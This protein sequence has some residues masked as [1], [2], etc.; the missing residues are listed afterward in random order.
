MDKLTFNMHKLL[1]FI[2]TLSI[3]TSCRKS[4]RDND[5]ET[6]SAVA[7]T[8]AFRIAN[9]IISLVDS[10]SRTTPGIYRTAQILS[11]C[12]SVIV[13]TLSS[14]KKMTLWYRGTNCDGSDGVKRRGKIIVSYDGKYSVTGRK[15]TIT[16]S[17][18]YYND[19]K[20]TGTIYISNSGLNNSGKR[21]YSVSISNFAITDSVQNKVN[22]IISS[23]LKRTFSEGD[24]TGIKE[25]D[26]FLYSGTISGRSTTGNTYK[27][28]IKTDLK[29]QPTCDYP[30]SGTLELIPTNLGVRYI[31]YGS[32]SCDAAF[33][34]KL[35]EKSEDM[36]IP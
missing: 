36:T 23:S 9:N 26:V 29:T 21:M 15:A 22:E 27:V 6:T 33:N 35:Y 16:F 3:L 18:F 32:G 19:Q 24:T 1:L 30:L 20:I 17:S 2:L 14:P 28:T 10:K 5:T 31:D 25:D 34:L 8:A 12:D 7:H 13:D 4:E 11:S